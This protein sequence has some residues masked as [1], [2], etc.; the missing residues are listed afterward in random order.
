MGEIVN[1][2]TARKAKARAAA[3]T[4]AAERRA[5]FGRT[6]AERLGDAAEQARTA[7]VVDGAFVGDGAVED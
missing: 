6:K 3:A 2:R 5:R 1:L 7:R 4:T